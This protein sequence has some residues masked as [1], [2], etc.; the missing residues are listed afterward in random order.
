MGA[1]KAR[2]VPR[3]TAWLTLE[4]GL[5][6]G[7]HTW[8]V[9]SLMFNNIKALIVVLFFAISI[10]A[11][12]KSTCLRFMSEEDFKRRRTVWF[13]ITVAVFVSP[14][15]W[16]YALMAVP[17]AIWAGSKDPNPVA[18]ATMVG[19][20][21][22]AFYKEVP[23]LFALTQGM[24]VAFCIVAPA[25]WRQSL[26][27]SRT[28][29][30]APRQAGNWLASLLLFTFLT[31]Q[32]TPYWKAESWTELLRREFVQVVPT[33]MGFWVCT[34]TLKSYRSIHELIAVIVLVSAIMAPIALFESMRGWLLYMGVAQQWDASPNMFSYL[35]R[36]GRLRALAITDHSLAL[37]FMMALSFGFCL[38]LQRFVNSRRTAIAA[39][40]LMW[41]GMFAAYSRGP[42]I[43]A[44][45]LMLA[46]FWLMPKGTGR[47]VKASILAGLLL[48][49]FAATPFGA[50]IID[51]LPLVGTQEKGNLEY[52]QL[53]LDRSLQ[54][55]PLHP[56]F[57]DIFVLRH[58]EDLRQGQG[59]IDIVNGFLLIALFCGLVPLL[60]LLWFLLIVLGKLQWAAL[61]S[62]PYDMNV[63]S[64]GSNLIACIF[65][66][67][68]FTWVAR[69][70]GE[71]V[72]LS[73][74]GLAYAKLV[75][76][77]NRSAT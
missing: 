22:P 46:Y 11:L 38:H 9:A 24:I 68:F 67:L 53:L 26:V 21:A 36:G 43:A 7:T 75:S 44:V 31:L 51:T 60:I 65:A 15:F 57:G 66:A 8:P 59:I 71:L 3:F 72:M 28:D 39:G 34:R 16:L 58:M 54:L 64:L 25:L 14:S 70:A 2:P 74:V 61:K 50:Q 55:I 18:M 12:A 29:V 63:S 23:H 47:I 20:A 49:V 19:S 4:S 33:M 40:A 62:R 27:D 10:F 32:V 6:N 45:I 77:D 48:A 76:T 56:W 42:W 73:G 41:G 30:T 37:G 69:F 13:I 5:G 1:L 35:M 17:V 52:R